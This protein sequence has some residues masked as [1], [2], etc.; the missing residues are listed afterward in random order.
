MLK[1]CIM[2]RLQKLLAAAGYGSRRACEEIISQG[3]V[4]V[5]GKQAHLGQSADPAHDTITVD[6]ARLRLTAK[7][8]YIIINKPY[9]IVS[10]LF[11]EM[12]RKTVRD[13]IP[14]EGQLAPVGRLDAHSTGLLLLTDDGD[15]TNRLTH[16]R[17]QH[18]KEY[19]VFVVGW[20]APEALARWQRGI[21]LPDFDSHTRDGGHTAPAHVDIMHVER[22]PDT[23]QEG[24]WLR[25]VMREGRKRQIR[26]VAAL[27]GHPVRK[28]VRV[29]I[30]PLQLGNLKPGQWRH[31]TSKELE[32]LKQE[33]SEQGKPRKSKTKKD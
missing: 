6:G 14:L 7:H 27:L 16:P 4:S 17:Y 28:L 29:R 12:G 20:P 3:R 18:E 22:D 32:Q 8:T 11:D 2:E 13:L 23:N 5:N 10:T 15:L 26:R 1:C 33:V 24:T 21:N 31:V 25:V 19:H 30:G 9:G